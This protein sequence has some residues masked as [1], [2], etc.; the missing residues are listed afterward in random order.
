MNIED[1]NLG[2]PPTGAGGDTIRD[3]FGKTNQNFGAAKQAL[4]DEV[5]TREQLLATQRDQLISLIESVN[6]P[7]PALRADFKARSFGTKNEAGMFLP[8]AYSDIFSLSAPS[9]KWVWNAQ[10]QLVEVP[11]GQPAWDHDPVTG[12]PLGQRLE[13]EATNGHTN[14]KLNS[15]VSDYTVT[16]PSDPYMPDAKVLTDSVGHS[17]NQHTN[18][19]SEYPFGPTGGSAQALRVIYAKEGLSRYVRIG[20]A[21]LDG[22]T[23]DLVNREIVP[24]SVTGDGTPRAVSKG[25]GWWELS[26]MRTWSSAAANSYRVSYGSS[27]DGDIVTSQIGDQITLAY[28]SMYDTSNPVPGSIIP[29]DGTAVTRAADV[30]TI[31]NVD[32]AAWFDDQEFTILWHYR[33]RS[34]NIGTGSSSVSLSIRPNGPIGYDNAIGIYGNNRWYVYGLGNGTIGP[35]DSEAKLAFSIKSDRTL[36]YAN[37]TLREEILGNAVINLQ[38]AGRITVSLGRFQGELYDC[39]TFKRVLT[40]AELQELTS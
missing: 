11:A 34:E 7:L 17:S 8:C 32:T 1:I 6:G 26:F 20:R 12:Q 16:D 25:N 9:P 31:E 28:P 36:I 14:G 24:E 40:A 30:A 22:F 3:A 4:E 37:G 38:A 18:L 35:I 2:D 27:I 23:F 10:G 15:A 5:Q 13:D 29:T 39:R 21:G 33:L 19:S